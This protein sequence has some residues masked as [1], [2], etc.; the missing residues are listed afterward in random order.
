MMCAIMSATPA[1]VCSGGSVKVSSGFIT[2]NLGRRAL[3]VRSDILR[4]PSSLVIT[5]LP[6]PSLPAAGIVSTTPTGSAFSITAFPAQKSQKS[7]S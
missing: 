3:S 6:L 4:M 7:P 2:A 1:A 5:E